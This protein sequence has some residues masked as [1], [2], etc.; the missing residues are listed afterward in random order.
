VVIARTLSSYLARQ[1]L[2]WCGGV[3]GIMM[4]ITFL[5]DYLELIRR[6][7][8]RPEATLGL[9]LEMAM[10]KL[11]HM[12]QEVLPFGILFGTMLAF[13]RLTRS[14]E[15]VVARAAGVSVWQFL[16]PAELF[17]L[18]IGVLAVTVFNPVASVMQA[19]F[20]NLEARVLRGSTDQFTLTHSGLWLRETDDQGNQRMLH[21]EH[22]SQNDSTLEHVTILFFRGVDQFTERV[23]AKEARLMPGHWEITDGVRWQLNGE[24][25]PFARLQLATLLTPR[26]IQESFASP[27]TMSFW[28]LP[29]FIRLLEV[30]G[31]STQ[32]HRLYFNALLARPFLLCAMVLI[33]ATFSLRMQRRGGATLMIMGGVATAFALFF[34]SDIVFALGLSATIP[35]ALAAWTPAGVS[36]LMGAAMLLHLEDG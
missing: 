32:R 7:A 23:D 15:L 17:A 10:L 18:V 6:G 11:P 3:F 2:I 22:S 14:N 19:S 36:M 12:A 16:M 24:S 4:T 5:L 29:G 9:L 30:S 35:V 25:E 21:A 28:D 13:W 27:E 31:F 8:A 33:A 20:E 1:V 34:L 26:K